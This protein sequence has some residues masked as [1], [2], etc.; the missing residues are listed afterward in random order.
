MGNAPVGRGGATVSA[1]AT[2]ERPAAMRITPAMK[3]PHICRPVPCGPIAVT[4]APGRSG[5]KNEERIPVVNIPLELFVFVG[6]LVVQS[7]PIV[8]WGGVM[9][10]RVRALE[11]EVD[12]LRGWRHEQGQDLLERMAKLEATLEARLSA[13][14][15]IL[16][17]M[18]REAV[19]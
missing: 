8:W 6:G 9:Q 17:N 4:M 12:D 10:T 11:R 18:K 14:V 2:T 1:A 15:E 13:L 7:L 3:L 5:R 16:N 19:R